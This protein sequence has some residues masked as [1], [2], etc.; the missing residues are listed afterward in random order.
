MYCLGR[1]C[2]SSQGGGAAK[3]PKILKAFTAW[4]TERY[5]NVNGR[6][7]RIG[8]HFRGS[9]PGNAQ[10]I[11]EFVH[12]LFQVINLAGG[13]TLSQSLFRFFF[14]SLDRLGHQA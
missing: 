8:R 4:N 14:R 11:K 7:T 6:N 13:Q 9:H 10:F 1:A 3:G 5:F 12:L 2:G